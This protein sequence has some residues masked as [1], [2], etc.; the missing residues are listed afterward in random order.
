MAIGFPSNLYS[1]GAVELDSTPYLNY[2]L[3]T[4]ARTRA[5]DEALDQYYQNM[6]KNVN[7]EGVRTQ[8]IPR[9]TEK[10]NGWQ[11]F[12]QQNRD[13]IKNPRLDGGRAQS[14]FQARYLDAQNY[15]Q[16]SKNAAKVYADLMPVLKD[17]EK[18]SRIPESVI[19]D[20]SLHD[21]ELDNPDR[22]EFD[23][24][25]L[26]FD[27]KPLDVKTEEAYFSGLGKRYKMD[28]RITNSVLDPKTYTRKLTTTLALGDEAKEGVASTGVQRY[29]FDPSFKK[30]IDES[31]QDKRAY[32]Q[33]NTIFK[34]EF[35]KDIESGEEGAIAYTLAG[36]QQSYQKQKSEADWKARQDYL[37]GQRINLLNKRLAAQKAGGKDEEGWVNPYVDVLKEMALMNPPSP[38]KYKSGSVV[39]EYDIP[40]DATIA[41]SL[42]RGSGQ[43]IRE[44][45]FLR[46]NPKTGQFRPIFIKYDDKGNPIKGEGATG[47]FAV[48]ES[49]SQPISE[50]QFKLNLGGNVTPTQRTL[51]MKEALRRKRGGKSVQYKIKGE[52][53]SKK[54]LN[55]MGYKDDEIEQFIKEGK[56]SQ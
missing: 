43:G 24:S 16:R 5:K 49:L 30:H 55:D 8:D 35:G 27:P 32:D 17:P 14:E 48:D 34:K 45:E 18:R 25:K 37:Q 22:I 39:D 36:M 2:Q 20:L 50:V 53:Y 19:K 46:Y 12:Y 13:A 11:R 51:E 21:L 3:Q 29:G 10:V 26:V 33:L 52:T 28:E 31:L 44:P 4:E 7:S 54:Q 23:P 42:R 6:F 40:I 41:K 47:K 56:I 9:F 1:G 38:Y 15:T